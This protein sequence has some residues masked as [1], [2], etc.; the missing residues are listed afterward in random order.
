MNRT[1]FIHDQFQND[2]FGTKTIGV[3]VS[4]FILG[5]QLLNDVSCTSSHHT[6]VISLVELIIWVCS[7]HQT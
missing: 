3:C 6:C 7:C 4:L 5:N 2:S 1:N